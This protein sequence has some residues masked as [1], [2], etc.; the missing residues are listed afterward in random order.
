MLNLKIGIKY[1][2]TSNLYI[3]DGLVNGA[4]G[5]LKT[6]TFCSEKKKNMPFILWLSFPEIRIG[7]KAKEKFTELMSKDNIDSDCV[8]IQQ[9]SSSLS[10]L[11]KCQ[12]QIFRKQ[13]PVVPAEV[14]IVHKSQ[15][16]TFNEVCL[17]LS[18]KSRITNAMM[19]VALSQVT[20]ISGLYITGEFKLPKTSKKEHGGIARLF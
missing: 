19:Y 1:I 18:I 6:I 12:Y 16:Q 14:L 10:V 7:R 20:K 3:E 8:P 17:D 15:G 9:I 13:F 5:I 11:Q 2:V 4:C